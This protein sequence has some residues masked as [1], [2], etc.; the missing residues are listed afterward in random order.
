MRAGDLVLVN[1]AAFISSRSHHRDA[2][3]CDILEMA[4]DRILVRTRHP[5]RIFSLWVGKEWIDGAEP[6]NMTVCGNG[7]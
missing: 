2:V 1:V 4:T 7:R 6:A 3:P 5:Y